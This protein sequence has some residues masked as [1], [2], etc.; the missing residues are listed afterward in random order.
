ML[1]KFAEE[2]NNLIEESNKGNDEK[3]NELKAQYD[4]LE[5]AKKGDEEAH[6]VALEKLK[7]EKANELKDLSESQEAKYNLLKNEM[8]EKVATLETEKAENN[9]RVVKMAEKIQKNKMRIEE[10]ETT[11]QNNTIDLEAN[12]LE[13][14]ELRHEKDKL[15][16]EMTENSKL[17]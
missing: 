4:S 13:M 6:K 11:I 10:L 2:R 5:S 7:E 3:F 8:D 17:E 14:E 12:Q 1:L 16:D 9:D 15:I